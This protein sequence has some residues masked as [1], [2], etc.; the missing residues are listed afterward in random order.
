MG[1]AWIASWLPSAV[2]STTS[3]SMFAARSGTRTSVGHAV[4][5]RRAM[6]LHPE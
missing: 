5:A 2:L 6:K 4:L 3:S 1:I